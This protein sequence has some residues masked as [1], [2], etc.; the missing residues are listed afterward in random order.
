M[1]APKIF[2]EDC[3]VQ[4]L[5][6]VLARDA[7][8]CTASLS[9][10]AG[11]AINVL[12]G[13][14][15]QTKRTDDSLFVKGW[16]GDSHTVDRKTHSYTI[17]RP[18]VTTVWLLQQDK[19]DD[20]I[21]NRSLA[22]GGFAP[23]LLICH[24]DCQPQ[25]VDRTR[26]LIGSATK[27]GYRQALLSLLTTFRRST[28]PLTIDPSLEAREVLDAYHDTIVDRR[29]TDLSDITSYAARW[30]EQAWRIAVC[31]HAAKW[32]VQA[33]SESLDLPTAK[34]AIRI[35]E[36]FAVQQLE[37]LERSR[38]SVNREIEDRIVLAIRGKPQG[39]TARDIY[40]PL[41][42]KADVAEPILARM[43]AAGKIVGEDDRPTGGGHS[44]R[45]YRLPTR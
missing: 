43:E 1:L 15:N 30:A 22:D 3:T 27:E 37:L 32:G 11:E 39:A 18:C 2:T 10:D 20:V 28:V 12:F 23:R 38:A 25:Y 36:W 45:R 7:S 44:T 9:A 13:R 33:G 8:E 42:M 19:L 5:A 21:N 34:S 14:Y 6:D 4:A 16:T 24:T 41:H 26:P 29:R 17:V 31:L 40:K 35:A